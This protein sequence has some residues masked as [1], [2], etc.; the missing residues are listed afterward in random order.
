MKHEAYEVVDIA[1]VGIG[2]FNLS[3]AALVEPRAELRARF[4]E[5]Q[6][7]FQWHPGLLFPE[8]TIQVSFIKDLVT[9]ADPT[10]PYSFLSFLFAKK[11]IYRFI[12]A[13]LP[14]VSRMEFNQYLRWVCDSLTNLEF[15]QTAEAVFYDGESLVVDLGHELVRTRN[16]VLGSGLHPVIPECAY[17]HLGPTVFH[18][19]RFLKEDPQTKGKRVVVIGGGQTGA[20][21]FYHL[22][23]DNSILPR[24][25][26]WVSRRPNFLPL[27]DSPFTNELFTPSYSDYFYNLRREDKASLLAHQKL[28]SDG[29]SMDLLQMIYRRMYELEFLNGNHRVCRLYPN[30]ELAGMNRHMGGELSVEARDGMTGQRDSIEADIVVLCTGSEYKLPKYLEPLTDRI[31]LDPEGLPIREDF[32]VRWDGPRSLNIYVQNG[33]R[34]CRGVADPNL[35]LMA[36]RSATIINSITGRCTY[37]VK[38]CSTAF[39]LMNLE[40]A[41]AIKSGGLF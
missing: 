19:S 11:R 40:M 7:E 13:N 3:I 20:E 34:H 39:D 6:R 32:S 27:D 17:P 18:A 28:A 26:S 14:R 31:S 37:D 36:W 29:V 1:G 33:A 2:P 4:F 23:A 21:V 5:R 24:E 9:L 30:H 10:N 22:L 41:G 35:S 12:N 8:A 25:L 16:V 38:E 15:G